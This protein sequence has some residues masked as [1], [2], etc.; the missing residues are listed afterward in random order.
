M[1][2]LSKEEYKRLFNAKYQE[3]IRDQDEDRRSVLTK[4]KY[5]IIIKTIENFNSIPTKDRTSI[6][7]KHV[8]QYKVITRDQQPM[9][10]LSKEVEKHSRVSPLTTEYVVDYDKVPRVVH[11]D[12]LFD[13]LYEVHIVV[14]GHE[15]ASRKTHER[16]GKICSNIPRSVC[17]IFIEL[18]SCRQKK[19]RNRQ[20]N[21]SSVGRSIRASS[22]PIPQILNIRGQLDLID[23][24]HKPDG[25]FQWILHYQDIA[26]KFSHLRALQRCDPVEVA[27]ELAK[28]FLSQGA[29][30]VL[31]SSHT[32]AFTI[33]LLHEL[34]QLW[35]AAIIV[36]GRAAASPLTGEDVAPGHVSEEQQQQQP[37]MLVVVDAS[38]TNPV[39]VPAVAHSQ[40]H[41]SIGQELRAQVDEWLERS[42]ADAKWSIG[43]HFI[44]NKRNN[45]QHQVGAKGTPFSLHFGRR[46]HA[47]I[48]SLPLDTAFL[49]SVFRE[50]EVTAALAKTPGLTALLLEGEGDGGD[51][52]EGGAGGHWGRGRYTG[53]DGCASDDPG[54]DALND[55]EGETTAPAPHAAAASLSL[56][57]R[58]I[59][60][61]PLASLP[62]TGRVLADDQDSGSDD[63]GDNDTIAAGAAAAF[64]AQGVSGLESYS[65]SSLLLDNAEKLGEVDVFK[66]SEKDS[67]G[68]PEGRV[69]GGLADE[70]KA[71]SGPG[72]T[73]GKRK[74]KPDEKLKDKAKDKEGG[75]GGSVAMAF[76]SKVEEEADDGGAGGDG[77]RAVSAGGTEAPLPSLSV[78][79]KGGQSESVSSPRSGDIDADAPPHRPKKPKVVADM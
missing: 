35:P 24:Q 7:Y 18:C 41:S 15:G 1:D 40:L 58:N 74:A 19:K 42:S 2:D 75:E 68:G 5:D 67:A 54:P 48:S 12:E 53:T 16:L 26:T 21:G 29:P 79:G 49:Q 47:T 66:G 9:L 38:V 62:G 39:P 28:I 22:T 60:S 3:S 27:E 45:H 63:D 57:L 30:S 20:I 78:R 4:E 23:M 10:V 70:T 65:S 6:M 55:S 14:G 51:E 13:V 8:K 37:A 11:E 64:I 56:L 50:D 77:A 71:K 36:H 76:V 44:A 69:G 73:R 33:E 52:C 25:D 72:G 61:Q 34:R 43:V 17:D 31:Q 46:M 32:E 59:S